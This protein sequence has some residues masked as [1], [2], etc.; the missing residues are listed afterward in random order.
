MEGSPKKKKNMKMRAACKERRESR[1]TSTPMMQTPGDYFD[2][3]SIPVE[4]MTK[5]HCTLSKQLTKRTMGHYLDG[6]LA[7]QF[8]VFV[9]REC[10]VVVGTWTKIQSKTWTMK[11]V[12]QKEI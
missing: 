11:I 6:F 5:E 8:L 7:F 1:I 4:L 9:K 3:V 2:S 12:Y 10:I